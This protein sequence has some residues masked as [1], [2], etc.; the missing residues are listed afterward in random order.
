MVY[1]AVYQA[2]GED[3]MTAYIRRL[4]KLFTS[5]KAIRFHNLNGNAMIRN[6]TY[7]WLMAA[8]WLMFIQGASWFRH[9]TDAEQGAVEI[10]SYVAIFIWTY[11]A[12]DDINRV[13]KAVKAVQAIPP[14]V[15]AASA[16][17]DIATRAAFEAGVAVGE[18]Q[19][20]AR[21]QV[22]TPGFGN[23]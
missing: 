3:D 17:M 10:L 14:A 22:H 20:R 2:K 4:L 9:W 5:W 15:K 19:A 12:G 11:C 8:F 16:V 7:L 23:Y 6:R 13:R 21:R 18:A 1:P